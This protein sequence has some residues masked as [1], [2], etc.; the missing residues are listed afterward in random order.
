MTTAG[1]LA[2]GSLRLTPAF[3]VSQWR[4]WGALAAHSCGGS[5]GLDHP[6]WSVAPRSL[7]TLGSLTSEGTVDLDVHLIPRRNRQASVE[8]GRKPQTLIAR[9][10][11][12]ATSAGPKAAMVRGAGNPILVDVRQD[13][14]QRF[15][16]ADEAR[17]RPGQ[18]DARAVPTAEGT[19]PG[20]CLNTIAAPSSC[21][22]DR[23]PTSIKATRAS[24]GYPKPR[25][26]TLNHQ[27]RQTSAGRTTSSER[28][29]S[30][31]FVCDRVWPRLQG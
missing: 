6:G 31:G 8:R 30:P 27:G 22:R 20:P 5:R 21:S 7:F 16:T 25:P 28:L 23:R 2:C 12:T 9:P 1:L 24:L 29:D 17:E 13:A 26:S 19:R 10:P 4:R 14:T 18:D 15:A 3:P 11:P